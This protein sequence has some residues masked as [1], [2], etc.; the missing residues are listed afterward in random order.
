MNSHSILLRAANDARHILFHFIHIMT[1]SFLL[2]LL[3]SKRK[4]TVRKT[5]IMGYSDKEI[6]IRFER[7]CSARRCRAA[8]RLTGRR[9]AAQR[10]AAR[11][12][13]ELRC[14][15]SFTCE[16]LAGRARRAPGLPPPLP[17]LPRRE[18]CKYCLHAPRAA[19]GGGRGRTGRRPTFWPCPTRRCRP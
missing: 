6:L 13:A 14:L 16:L 8:H 1:Q 4:G 15:P 18:Q 5:S 7:R 19:A 11:R 17:V 3:T 9:C 10:G 12:G 2:Q